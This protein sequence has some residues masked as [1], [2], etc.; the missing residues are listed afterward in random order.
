MATTYVRNQAT[1]EFELV[2]PGGASTDT[3]L[4]LTGKP[5]DA[6]AVGSAL[7]MK[8]NQSTIEELLGDKID[9]YQIYYETNLDEIVNSGLYYVHNDSGDELNYP[10]GQN[11]HLIVIE[12]NDFVRQLFFRG[13]TQNVND[14]QWYSRSKHA[15]VNDG[16]WGDWW[17]IS[18]L[19]LAWYGRAALDTEI[20]LGSYYGCQA[21]VISGHP[22]SDS[23]GVST[24]YVPRN[25][26]TTDET[27]YALT[28]SDET[29]Y[30]GF[31]VYYKESDNQAYAK[32]F[33]ATNTTE[34]YLRYVY[35]VS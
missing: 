18:G 9:Q 24:I 35:R 32:I 15:T 25:F 8:V 7:A 13:G 31:R 17:L 23:S 26:F 12:G 29:G 21:W 4:S 5:A 30:I 3:T 1:G 33:A 27:K 14:I 11:G 20:C 22:T 19:E 2:G 6:A 16:A 28:I 34:G 10:I